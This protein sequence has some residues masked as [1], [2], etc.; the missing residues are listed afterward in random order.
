MLSFSWLPNEA[1]H[2]GS[3]DN[4]DLVPLMSSIS[5]WKS[6]RF[7]LEYADALIMPGRR[8]LDR[9]AGLTGGVH[10]AGGRG[11]QEGQGGRDQQRVPQAHA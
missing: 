10:H 8:K 5:L 3:E 4:I 7:F 9:R 11:D 2:L 1:F 6:R